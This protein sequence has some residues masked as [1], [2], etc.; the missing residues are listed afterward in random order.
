MPVLYL[1]GWLRGVVVGRW[2]CDREVAGSTPGQCIAGQQL[3]ASCSHPCASVAKQYNLVP[4]KE[5]FC[6]W[7]GNRSS[8]IA[9]A[10]R[11]R[12]SGLST[13]R[14]KGQC[15]RDE[16]PNYAPPEYGPPLPFIS[17]PRIGSVYDPTTVQ[18]TAGRSCKLASR[19]QAL[20]SAVVD[21][22]WW[23][24]PVTMMLPTHSSFCVTRW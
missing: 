19:Q 2:T 1:L 24:S 17:A 5:L 9:L 14:L 23:C 22:S 15:A 7:E 8:G 16:R 11:H 12:L 21:V 4:A 10:M 13:Y 6:G 3:R 18:C 20:L